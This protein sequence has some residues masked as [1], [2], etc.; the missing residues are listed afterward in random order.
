MGPDDRRTYYFDTPQG[1]VVQSVMFKKSQ[2]L[3]EEVSAWAA[4][5][6]VPWI[7]VEG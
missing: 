4:A 7:R 2:F 6:G 5:H 1:A 3:P